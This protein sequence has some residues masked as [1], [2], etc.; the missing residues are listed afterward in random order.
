MKTSEGEGV[1]VGGSDA[2]TGVNN[3]KKQPHALFP[4]AIVSITYIL[5]TVTDGAVRMIVLLHAYGKAFTA[6]EI[7]IMFSLYELMGVLTNLIAGIMGARWGD[8][9][10]VVGLSALFAWDDAWSKMEAIAYVT[11]AQALCGIAKDLTKLG[12]K[13]VTK[14]VTPDEKQN[15]LFVLVSGLTGLKNSFKGVGYFLGAWLLTISYAT[16]L[17]VMIA[18]IVIALPF[19]FFGL[20]KDLGRVGKENVTLKK[21]LTQ[22]RNTKYLSLSRVFL[23]G[24]RDLWFEIPLPFFLRDSIGGMGWSRSAVGAMLA[25]YII[26]YGQLQSWTP[27]LVLK[28]LK[29]SPPNKRVAVLWNVLLVLCPLFLGACVSTEL[30]DSK[31]NEEKYETERAVLVV[32]GIAFFAF[33]FAVNSAIHSYLVVRYAEGNK[34]SMSVGFYYMA[35]AFG[36][37]FGTIL[38]GVIYTAFEND[39][40]TG[41]AVCFWASSA[42]VLLSA[43]FETFL[44]EE[45]DDASVGDAEK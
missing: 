40:R 1:G 45:G 23:F 21:A 36:R 12:G 10:D 14:L 3:E 22:N 38:S 18:L 29:Q 44:E 43:F 27:A 33:L 6:M 37:L 13:T 7:A 30:F 17:I 42:S 16:S 31:K 8:S 28:P 15:R 41:F 39:V 26:V 34:L 25:G 9:V 11:G 35:N 4:F 24:S 32:L 20:S 5:F 2:E 19:G